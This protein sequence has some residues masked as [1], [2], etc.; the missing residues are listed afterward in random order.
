MRT[1]EPIKAALVSKTNF[2]FRIECLDNSIILEL[3]YKNLL[4]SYTDYIF[5][6]LDHSLSTMLFLKNY[7]ISLFVM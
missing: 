5:A 4:F 1:W 7:K 3:Y 2:Y 6:L